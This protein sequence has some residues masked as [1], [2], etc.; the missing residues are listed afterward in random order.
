MTGVPKTLT[1]CDDLAK[2]A[3]EQPPQRPI[4]C[5]RDHMADHLLF[6]ASALPSQAVSTDTGKA[7]FAVYL[8]V[9]R[10]LTDA[11]MAHVARESCKRLKWFPTPAEC[12]E[13][14]REISPPGDERAA[15]LRLCSDTATEIMNRWCDDPDVEQDVPEAWHRIAI[16][17]GTLSRLPDGRL[18]SR[19]RVYGPFRLA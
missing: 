8:S 11:Q 17:R 15:T 1:E 13:I 4:A 16:E 6:M 3:R 14:A 7:R 9:L 19:R 2:W 5:D 10:D 12:L 18:V